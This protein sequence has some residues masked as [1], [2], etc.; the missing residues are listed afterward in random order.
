MR[1]SRNRLTLIPKSYDDAQGRTSFT[2]A[3][4]RAVAAIG[5]KLKSFGELQTISYSVH[6]EKSSVLTLGRVNPLSFT[7]GPR[8]IA[9]SMVFTIFNR[10]V[11]EE[12]TT[13]YPDDPID[14]DFGSV[15]VDQIPPF[16]VTI[17]FL[18]EDGFLSSLVI[19]G[20]DIVDDG[21]VM[22][23]N[24]MIIE[25]VK[26]YKARGLDLMWMADDGVW[27][28]TSR[29][30]R[31]L[32]SKAIFTMNPHFGQ[33]FA[34]S[35]DREILA[36]YKRILFSISEI[37]KENE[38]LETKIAELLVSS[39]GDRQNRSDRI[40]QQIYKNEAKIRTLQREARQIRV[41]I[42]FSSRTS[43]IDDYLER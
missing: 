30:Q 19:Y 3:N 10:E 41:L 21:Q 9:G 5:G 43:V 24:D 17:T 2:G 28:S 37:G 39:Y 27:H 36:A 42:N 22:S 20:I 31:K 25:N 34:L 13:V 6:R 1:E 40:Q 26:G 16:N 8:T 32:N 4:I 35:P 14:G 15:L 12:L 18:N 11:L 38:A 33:D 23:I 29:G 7:R